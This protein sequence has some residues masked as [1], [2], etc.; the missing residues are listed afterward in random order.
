MIPARG[1]GGGV[2]AD[3]EVRLDDPRH[4]PIHQ[5]TD[6]NHSGDRPPFARFQINGGAC[7]VAALASS[8]RRAAQLTVG[9]VAR[10][11]ARYRS[12]SKPLKTAY[13]FPTSTL[14]LIRTRPK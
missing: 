1:G 6:K 11:Q 9:G 4:R 14:K 7:V 3:G 10:P 8:A 13:I 5:K 12:A 2:S